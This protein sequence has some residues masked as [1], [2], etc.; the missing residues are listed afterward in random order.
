MVSMSNLPEE[1]VG[2]ETDNVDEYEFGFQL[3]GRKIQMK[4]DVK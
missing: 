2:R 1:P 4:K 3:P